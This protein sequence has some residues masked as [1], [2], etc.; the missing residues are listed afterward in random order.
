[1][2]ALLSSSHVDNLMFVQQNLF[3]AQWQTALIAASCHQAVEQRKLEMRTE[4]RPWTE[5]VEILYRHASKMTEQ[6]AMVHDSQAT[7]RAVRQ[8]VREQES[9]AQ[10][11]AGGTNVEVQGLL[12]SQD[13]RRHLLEVIEELLVV[14]SSLSSQMQDV[15]KHINSVLC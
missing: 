14:C 11:V 10:S 13:T 6:L 8:D 3:D 15:D 5:S 7:L 2:S 4:I 12:R 9:N 1:M